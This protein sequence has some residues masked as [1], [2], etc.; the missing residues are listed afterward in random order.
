MMNIDN[1]FMYSAYTVK[2]SQQKIG[3]SKDLSVRDISNQHL[4]NYETQIISETK[5]ETRRQADVLN[6]ADIGYQGNPIGELTQAE[7][8]E[9]MGE[10]GFFSIAQT[11]ERIANFVLMG[12]SDDTERL[13]S[14]R[15]GILQGFKEAEV[16]WGGELPEISHK[17]LSRALEM[18]DIRLNS[19]GAS[20]L[21]SNA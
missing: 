15:E 10:N 6:L 12:A 4:I 2:N 11:S 16:L 9:L 8:Q 20:I 3:D 5:A 14:G 13:K 21:D 19:L 7:A 18:I 1:S 17:T